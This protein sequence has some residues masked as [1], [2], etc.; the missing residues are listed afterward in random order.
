MDTNNKANFS[1][2]KSETLNGEFMV[3]IFD[4]DALSPDKNLPISVWIK[5][6]LKKPNKNNFIPDEEAEELNRLEDKIET[7]IMGRFVGRITFQ[8]IRE[9][10]FYAK[11][12]T[13]T[14][15]LLKKFQ[16]ER[17]YNF[18]FEVKSDPEWAI[19]A[20]YL[21]KIEE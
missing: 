14:E 9:L 3:G 16:N 7:L 10:Y 5:I 13:K 20:S 19:V 21:K 15:I 12:I 2:V 6:P 4:M 11:D 8:G 1:V 17:I 18:E